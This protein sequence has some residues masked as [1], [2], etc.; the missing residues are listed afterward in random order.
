MRE[1][2]REGEITPPMWKKKTIWPRKKIFYT[3]NQW[4]A[5]TCPGNFKYWLIQS[6]E[7]KNLEE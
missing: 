6:K 7:E 1:K 4:L 2:E 5:V 3:T